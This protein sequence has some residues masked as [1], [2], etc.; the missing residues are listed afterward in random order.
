VIVSGGSPP[1]LVPCHAAMSKVT[2]LSVGT[3]PGVSDVWGQEGPSGVT[4]LAGPPASS[5]IVS[6]KSLG[7]NGSTFS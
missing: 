7:W 1:V 6:P 4:G 2:L 3:G 5:L